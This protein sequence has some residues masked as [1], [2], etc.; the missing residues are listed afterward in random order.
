MAEPIDIRKYDFIPMP[1]KEKMGRLNMHGFC[2]SRKGVDSTRGFDGKAA[3]C[4]Y[5]RFC[6]KPY[7]T[8]DGELHGASGH[9]CGR[10]SFI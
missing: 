7:R 5:R 9:Y 10:E 2:F 3:D 8:M 4:R 1:I 6:E